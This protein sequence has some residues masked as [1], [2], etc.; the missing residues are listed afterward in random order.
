MMLALA[1]MPLHAQSNA[2]YFVATG[3]RLDDTYGFL[4]AGGQV[5]EH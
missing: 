5:K 1:A 2:I 4:T 3:Q